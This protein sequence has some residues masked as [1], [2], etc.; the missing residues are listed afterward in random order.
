MGTRVRGIACVIAGLL[1]I[2]GASPSWSW[3][4]QVEDLTTC[5]HLFTLYQTGTA[6]FFGP[7][8]MDNSSGVPDDAP[9][10]FWWGYTIVSGS[11]ASAA[12]GVVYAYPKIKLNEAITLQGDI[13]VGPYIPL[14]LVQGAYVPMSNAVFH[15]G[16]IEAKT[17]WGTLSYG[18]KP[19]QQG[20][21][22]QFAGTFRWNDWVWYGRT[23]EMVDLALPF[24]PLT[25]KFG[26]N[27]WSI[28]GDIFAWTYNLQNFAYLDPFDTGGHHTADFYGSITYSSGDL[29]VGLGT[30]YK[31]FRWGPESQ[32]TAA[33]RAQFPPSETM[34]SE[35][36]IYF[37]YFNG[38]L[39]FNAEADWYYRTVRFQR[40]ANGT[41]YGAPEIHA[42]G[43]GRS[44]FAPQY[45]ES[46]RYMT[47]FGF[48]MGPMRVSLLYTSMPGWDRRH[49]VL[50][51]KQ[52][53][54]LGP[55]QSAALVFRPY[56]TIMSF[57]YHSGTITVLDMN[58]AQ[59][60]GARIDY[61]L[62]CNLDVSLSW[63][64]AKRLSKGYGWAFWRLPGALPI[65]AVGVLGNF[66][67]N[68]PA[69][70]D[71]DLGMEV[72]LTLRWKLLENWMFKAQWGMF[73]P[74]KW[75]NHA[76]IDKSVPG[77]DFQS[78]EPPT[79]PF[80]VNPD[81]SIDPVGMLRLELWTYI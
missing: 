32:Y 4:F 6:G 67:D 78:L 36:W 69:I 42:D 3:E 24:G 12:Y 20:L 63:L 54:V 35:G 11:T 38:R 28:G 66:P 74:G 46:W 29:E 68:V 59:C 18:K 49:G 16:W 39:F 17:P 57:F 10:N 58:D 45:V 23:E 65:P 60:F 62:A 8:D 25:L 26:V 53:F 22:L 75:W 52:S 34:T 7:Y 44:R 43:S 47:E 15:T 13:W 5:A 19:F 1:F 56:A 51:D 70:P 76:C 79:Y 37:K 71:D 64:K 31:A 30:L 81:R 77:W 50:I 73:W 80:G 72:N 41:F 27:P 61:A 55:E 9:R 21:G 2:G 40:S 48:L 33:L 14:G